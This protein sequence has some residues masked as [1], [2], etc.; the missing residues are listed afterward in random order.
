MLFVLDYY[1]FS[2]EQSGVWFYV[3]AGGS[4]QDLQCAGAST[5]ISNNCF[6]GT[7]GALYDATDQTYIPDYTC[8]STA[9]GNLSWD[10][11]TQHDFSSDEVTRFHI[12]SL[13]CDNSYGDYSRLYDVEVWVR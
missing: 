2:M 10:T 7:P 3:T 13:M 11:T 1:A 12:T 6:T 5:T 4:E 8:S 9:S